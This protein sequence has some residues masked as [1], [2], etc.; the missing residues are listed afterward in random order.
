MGAR[1]RGHIKNTPS[2]QT[3][4]SNVQHASTLQELMAERRVPLGAHAYGALISACA[5]PKDLQRARS[6]RFDMDGALF[7]SHRSADGDGRQTRFC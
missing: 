7:S 5:F 4:K 3:N 6:L 2:K 1:L